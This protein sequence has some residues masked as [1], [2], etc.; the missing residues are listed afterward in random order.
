MK[1]IDPNDP[2][3]LLALAHV[4]IAAGE[5][6][7]THFGKVSGEMKADDSPVTIADREAEALITAE[8]SQI[9][10]AIQVIGEEAC[11]EALPERL[12]DCFFLLDPLDG[13]KEFLNGRSDFTVNIALI[14]AG[15]AQAGVIYAPAR[16]TLYLSGAQSAF[17]AQCPNHQRV[18]QEGL[19]PIHMRAPNPSAL[20]V[21]ASRSHLSDETRDYLNTLPVAETMSAGSSLKFCLLAEG[22][23]D[24]Y[25]RH[26]RTMEWDTAAGHAIVNSAGGQVCRFDG[27]PLTYG[28]LADGLANPYFVASARQNNKIK[29]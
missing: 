9:A 14:I 3:F 24:L 5:R 17:T 18:E 29:R 8:L 6:I 26:G 28:K 15:Q 11:A 19:H 7:M 2:G 27:S 1:R 23:A 16:E 10:P 4:S 21:V 25:P 13:T 20:T 12:D 22:V